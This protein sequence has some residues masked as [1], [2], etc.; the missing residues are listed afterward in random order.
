LA[1]PEAAAQLTGL[2]QLIG[3]DINNEFSMQLQ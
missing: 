2:K 3:L 1:Y